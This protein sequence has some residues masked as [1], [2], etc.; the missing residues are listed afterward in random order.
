MLL[1]GFL[2]FDEAT[3]VALFAKIQNAD[4]TYPS[5]FT[6]Q[7]K[8]LLNLMLVVDP[9]KR[10]TLTSIKMHP[11]FHGPTVNIDGKAGPAIDAEAAQM[12]PTQAQL[13]AA[14]A[15]VDVQGAATH[16]GE[17]HID[18]HYDDTFDDY[19][20]HD[21]TKPIKLNAFELVSQCGG[22][23]LDRMFSPE[24]YYSVP[25]SDTSAAAAAG[26]GGAII[27]GSKTT[28]Q[29]CY[30]FTSSNGMTVILLAEAI[31]VA[32]ESM[33]FDVDTSSSLAIGLLRA[34]L[35]TAK[36][37]VGFLIHVFVVSPTT[38]LVEIKK[39]KGDLLE[40]NNAFSEL[41]NNRIGHLLNKP[42]K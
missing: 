15:Q 42:E 6:A 28:N 12:A 5:W 30:H 40:W 31:R 33:C 35:L 32:L 3:I 38:N 14:V 8:D 17:E 13:D 27:F 24:I 34:S 22:L 26:V 9:K 21:V 25:E 2:P 37:R 7:V 39:G 36:G 18:D 4:F 16:M 19:P 1:A 41:V 11:W 23:M 29:K 10:A 20:H